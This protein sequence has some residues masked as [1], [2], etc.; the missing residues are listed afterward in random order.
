MSERTICFG[1]T[2]EFLTKTVRDMVTEGSWQK[3]LKI[4]RDSLHGMSYDQALGI[5]SG[6]YKLVGDSRDGGLDMVKDNPEDTKE[7]HRRVKF[8]Y[9]GSY[10]LTG[11]IWFRPYA[12]VTDFGIKDVDAEERLFLP[13]SEKPRALHY[14]D[15]PKEDKVHL[16]NYDQTTRAILFHKVPVP[17]LWLDMPKNPQKALDEYMKYH[18]PLD[19][20]GHKLWYGH[21]ECAWNQVAKLKANLSEKEQEE[22]ERDRMEEEKKKELDWQKKINEIATKK[23]GFFEMIVPYPDQPITYKVPLLP[24]KVWALKKHKERLWQPVTPCGYKLPYDDAIHTDWIIGAGIPL[25]LVYWNKDELLTHVI[26]EW[27]ERF[28]KEERKELVVIQ[29]S[30]SVRGVVVHPKPETPVQGNEII[31]VPNLRMD[32]YESAIKALAVIAETGGVM[33]HLSKTAHTPIVQLAGALKKY[34]PGQ[35]LIIDLDTEKITVKKS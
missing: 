18:L 25:D 22:L 20:R 3:A 35:V 7:Y 28:K 14:A 8:T 5:L 6:E 29:G 27:V 23:G 34:L 19:A 26:W 15:S 12:V 4:L 30:G 21:Y 32:Y 31:V 2:G 11:D 33:C 9:G 17:P 16:L 1:I 10:C 24:F 13:P